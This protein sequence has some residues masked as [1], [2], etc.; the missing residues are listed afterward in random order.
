[1]QKLFFFLLLMFFPLQGYSMFEPHSS[2]N[3]T[4]YNKSHKILTPPLLN[5]F[6]EEPDKQD[7]LSQT[8]KKTKGEDFL[9]EVINLFEEGRF[10][11]VISQLRPFA[12][13]GSEGGV[14]ENLLAD[15]LSALKGSYLDE[16]AKWYVE[17]ALKG[18]DEAATTIN[19]YSKSAFKLLNSDVSS[20]LKEFQQALKE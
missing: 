19:S 14:I 8:S 16:A 17:A 5:E 9:E 6:L 11:E 20:A 4:G 1:M 2:S 3:Q 10:E 13:K 18:N 12:L 15:A 7:L